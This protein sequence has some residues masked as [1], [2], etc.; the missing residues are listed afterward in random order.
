MSDLEE[1]KIQAELENIFGKIDRIIKRIDTED[2]A[3]T[4]PNEDNADPGTDSSQP[5]PP[6]DPAG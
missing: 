6:E 3:Q 4:A 1:E 2:P 5:K